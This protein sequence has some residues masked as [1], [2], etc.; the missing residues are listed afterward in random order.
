[1]TTKFRENINFKRNQQTQKSSKILP[2]EDTRTSDCATQIL[3]SEWNW[4]TQIAP[5]HSASASVPRWAGPHAQCGEP[6]GHMHQSQW[7][8]QSPSN[9]ENIPITLNPKIP[10]Q[11]FNLEYANPSTSNAIKSQITNF[12]KSTT[13]ITIQQIKSLSNLIHTLTPILK[14]SKDSNLTRYPIYGQNNQNPDDK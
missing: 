6:H 11:I 1:M 3:G 4:G 12:R 9:L 5:A 10:N 8:M 2:W 7:K 14:I 13:V